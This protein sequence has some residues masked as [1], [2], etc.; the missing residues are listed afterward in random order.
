MTKERKFAAVMA[1]FFALLAVSAFRKGWTPWFVPAG[2]SAAFILAG[3]FV[4]AALAP[5][6]RAW[7]AFARAL[8]AINAWIILTVF[9][10]AVM[11]PAGALLRAMG[12]DPLDLG[13]GENS[14]WRKAR[15]GDHLQRYD[16]S[17]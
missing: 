13:R 17:F 10:Y 3:T 9:Y 1:G 15:T 6:E 12:D 14:Y 11:T 5:L 7:M 8:G 2:A 16:K 4:P